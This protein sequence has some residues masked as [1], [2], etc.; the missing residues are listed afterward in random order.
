MSVASSSSL[1][2][3]SMLTTILM[4]IPERM[5]TVQGTTLYRALMSGNEEWDA[6]VDNARLSGGSRAIV[7]VLEIFGKI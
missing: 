6:L 2:K 7:S 5:L 1:P 4:M 3:R